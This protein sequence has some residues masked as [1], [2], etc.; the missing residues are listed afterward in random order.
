MAPQ[1][2]RVARKPSRGK[3]RGL[4]TLGSGPFNGGPPL[5]ALVTRTVTPVNLFFVR[6]HGPIPHI[7]A[8]T[9]R[10][11]V[12]GL[13]E[14]PL[15]LSLADLRARFPRA[16]VDAAIECAGNRRQELLTIAPVF[17]EPAWGPEAISD[18]VW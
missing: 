3:S 2:P 13:V 7:E 8:K 17:G 6:S 16:R 11:E 5:E 18:A 14:R 1:Q 9:Y 4:R 12:G 10:L 15:K